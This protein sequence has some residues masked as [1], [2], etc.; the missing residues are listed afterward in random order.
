MK[1]SNKLGVVLL[2]VFLMVII[3]GCS[4]N[5]FDSEG[6]G[7]LP[8]PSTGTT[9]GE[10]NPSSSVPVDMDKILEEQRSNLENEKAL[11]E[12]PSI[13]A[14]VNDTPVYQWQIE[15]KMDTNNRLLENYRT[16]LE[17][18]D[19]SEQE[20]ST[21][22]EIYTADLFLNKEDI[23]DDLIRNTVIQMEANKRNLIPTDEEVAA[24]AQEHFD[25][26]KRTPEIYTSAQLYMEVMNLTEEDYL[27]LIMDEHKKAEGQANLFKQITAEIENDA[28]KNEA[29]TAAVNEW[30][31]QADIVIINDQE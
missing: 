22:W 19:L 26:I 9:S 13:A 7:S 3:S 15:T 4:G 21:Y 11:R 18:M 24:K 8:A 28:D 5:S 29:F 14:T 6:A 27:R 1:Q 30:V 10:T 2:M 31:S 20:K 16:Q 12:D 25:N 17:T 23:L